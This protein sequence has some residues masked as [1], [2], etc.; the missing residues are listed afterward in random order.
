MKSINVV[1]QEALSEINFEEIAKEAA[2]SKVKQIVKES[3][4]NQLK[5]Y[6]TF[7]EKLN[8]HL[9]KELQI[10]FGRI[11]LPEYRTFLIGAVNNALAAFTTEDHAKE[12]VKFINE[13][14]VGESRDEIE[15]GRFWDELCQQISDSC[16]E[17]DTEKYCVEM[18]KEDSLYSHSRN[19]WSLSISL[20]GETS[21]R[22]KEII[23]AALSDG[24]IYNVNNYESY[25]LSGV[26]TWFKALH[27]RK[28]K[29]TNISADDTVVPYRD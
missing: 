23:R 3:V 25:E 28:T 2:I 16:D 1:I 4:E 18:K 24:V 27:F 14:V 6:S 8:E 13:K 11:Q 12:I 17:E 9:K 5:T 10:D 21:A 15:F 26:S 20:N 22:K 7:G 29:I 19:Y